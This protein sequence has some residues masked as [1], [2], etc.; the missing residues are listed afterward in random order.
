MDILDL[1]Y[2]CSAILLRWGDELRN[3]H[4]LELADCRHVMPQLKGFRL[5]VDVN[6]FM[7]A[8]KIILIFYSISKKSNV[9]KGQRPFGL[10]KVIEKLD[11]SI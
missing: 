3:T 7:E 1:L 9:N 8:K 4:N 10:K 6:R 11:F 5:L 2:S